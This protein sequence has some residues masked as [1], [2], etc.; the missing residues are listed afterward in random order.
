VAALDAR[1]FTGPFVLVRG[2]NSGA[3]TVAA[4][5]EARQQWAADP[6]VATIAGSA[7]PGVWFADVDPEPEDAAAG[8][9]AVEQLADWC[10]GHGLPWLVRASGRPGGRHLVVLLPAQL[11]RELRARAREAA[12]HHGVPIGLR[13]TLRLLGAPHR[14]GL[15]APVLA[16]TL[17]AKDLPKPAPAGDTATGDG[18]AVPVGRAG[19]RARRRAAEPGASRS[20]REFGVA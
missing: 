10:A 12:E 1:L 5:A 18:S 7:V 11:L 8:Q 17:R 4:A 14:A 13:R 15:P 6:E 16:G 2:D 9:A 19:R 20:G 3:G